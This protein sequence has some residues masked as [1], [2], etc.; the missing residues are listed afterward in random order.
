MGKRVFLTESQ[1]DVLMERQ[2]L[3]ESFGSILKKVATGMLSV[4]LAC[5]MIQS[6]KGVSPEEKEKMIQQV[7]QAAEENTQVTPQ[8]S[9]ALLN[10]VAAQA[11]STDKCP[12]DSINMSDWRR[13]SNEAIVTV[14]NAKPEQCNADVQHTASMFKLDLNA[15]ENHKIVALER[16]FMQKNGIKFGDLIMIKGT[17]RGRQDGVYQVQDLMNKRFA[18][19]DKVDILVND[20]IKYG[21]TAK[22]QHA[23]IFVLNN[24]EK[25]SDYRLG[26][27]PQAQI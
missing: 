5:S 23:E 2:M 3:N 16:T 7:E 27:A 8:S 24:L 20:S 17:Y 12:A 4:S 11:V 15:P 21:G 10:N 1:F 19:M 25:D 9:D 22:N 14:Y 6:C 13:I 18:G 26:M